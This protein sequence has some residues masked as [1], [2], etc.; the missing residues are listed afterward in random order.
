MFGDTR[1][2]LLKSRSRRQQQLNQGQHPDFLEGTSGIRQSEWKVRPAPKDLQDRRVEITGPVDRKMLINAL[3]SGA[4]C[5]MADLED[6]HSPHWDTTV[7]GQI[8]LREAVN[9]TLS[10]T[11]PEGKQ[12]QLDDQLATLIVR[13]RGWHLEEKHMRVDG[14]RISGAFFDFGLYLSI[15]PKPCWRWA[16]VPISTCRRWRVISRL[17]CGVMCLPGQSRSLVSIR[18]PFAVPY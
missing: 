14:R 5:F 4:K 8:N 16:V 12:Y 17:A 2:E 11:S 15:T 7:E 6:A 3:N 1:R 10:F 13:P 18:A 9:R